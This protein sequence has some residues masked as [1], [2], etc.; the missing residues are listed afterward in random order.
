MKLRE[1]K[2]TTDFYVVEIDETENWDN[3]FREENRIKSV[4]RVYLFDK[5][6]GIYLCEMTFSY[7]LIPL[8]VLVNP[9]E[10]TDQV[11]LNEDYSNYDDQYYNHYDIDA[12]I[13]DPKFTRGEFHELKDKNFNYRATKS[14][15]KEYAEKLDTL[16]E[17][18]VSNCPI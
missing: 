12:I 5:S 2:I 16:R 18:L 11:I 13:A 17:T 10:A 9:P 3:D 7:N 15:S 14:D 1:K 8:Y 4:S 6:I